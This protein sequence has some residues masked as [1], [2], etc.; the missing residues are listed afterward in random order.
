MKTRPGTPY[1]L[2]ATWDGSGVNFAIFSQRATKVELCLFDSPESRHESLRTAAAR[3]DRPGLARLPAGRAPR[4]A[5]RLSR[6]RPLR[7]GARLPLQPEQGAARAVRQGHR[8]DDRRGLTRCSATASAT[9][10]PISRSTS[11]TTPRYCRPERRDRPGV[12]LGQTIARRGTPWHETVIYE[13][14]VRGFTMRHP[15]RARVR[16]AAP[17]RRWAPTRSCG[18]CRTSASPPSS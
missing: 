9:R 10:P 5:L 17:T 3:A 2:G 11:A 7:S 15:A 8:P 18:T 4:A 1:P 13:M 16:C 14:H 6:P 12:H